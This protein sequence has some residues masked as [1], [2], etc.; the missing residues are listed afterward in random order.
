[1]EKQGTLTQS[2]AG[3]WNVLSHVW[4]S[5]QVRW[6]NAARAAHL[7]IE[8]SASQLANHPTV[9]LFYIRVNLEDI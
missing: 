1:M 9:G 2:K 3:L 6:P 7:T 8:A 4:L 5:D